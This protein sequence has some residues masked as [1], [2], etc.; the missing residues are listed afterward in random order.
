M[1]MVMS[2]LEMLRRFGKR[3]GPYLML[4]ILPGG[5]LFALVFFLYRLRKEP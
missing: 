4:G 2:R 1:Q 3:M 5:T